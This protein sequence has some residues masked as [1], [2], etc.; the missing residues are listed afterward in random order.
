MTKLYTTFNQLSIIIHVHVLWM[1]KYWQE[2][3]TN[4][5]Y[6]QEVHVPT[7]TLSSN[8]S[9]SQQN[10]DLFLCFNRKG[11]MRTR[12]RGPALIG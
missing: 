11:K 2:Y 1:S 5:A 6:I 12:T 10:G 3:T 8:L 7:T 4:E 9:R